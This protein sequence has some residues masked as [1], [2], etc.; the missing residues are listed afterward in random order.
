MSI[1][2]PKDELYQL[3]YTRGYRI[4]IDTVN[5]TKKVSFTHRYAMEPLKRTSSYSLEFTDEQI[6][7][8]CVLN[9]LRWTGLKV[10]YALEY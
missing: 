8:D 5:D 2:I 3:L 1:D 7:R 4:I 10:V 6:I 9:L